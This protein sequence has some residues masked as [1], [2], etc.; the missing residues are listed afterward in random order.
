[1]EKDVSLGRQLRHEE[2]KKRER[3][4]G[5]VEDNLIYRSSTGLCTSANSWSRVQT[6]NPARWFTSV[7][8]GIVICCRMAGTGNEWFA[9]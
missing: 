9:G 4:S 5:G 6:L 8:A 7:A 1:M 2:Q 3:G